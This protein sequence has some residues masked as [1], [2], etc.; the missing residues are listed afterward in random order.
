MTLWGAQLK[1]KTG[2]LVVALRPAS[3]VR[4]FVPNPPDDRR[5]SPGDMLIAIGSPQQLAQL[6]RLLDPSA[7][8]DA[9]LGRLLPAK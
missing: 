2:A 6:G 3:E 9:L 8:G 5:L 7:A 4:G 1:Q